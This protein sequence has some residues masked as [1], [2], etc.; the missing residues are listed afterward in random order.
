MTK[1]FI[2]KYIIILS[3]TWKA[4]QRYTPEIDCHAGRLRLKLDQGIQPADLVFWFHFKLVEIDFE[5]IQ[6][7]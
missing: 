7:K 1:L 3:M 4:R 2:M 6:S 5:W